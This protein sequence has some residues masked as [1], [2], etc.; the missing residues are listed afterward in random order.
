MKFC[1]NSNHPIK[2]VHR[3]T[4]EEFER[5][6]GRFGKLLT[7]LLDKMEAFLRVLTNKAICFQHSYIIGS[8]GL[9]RR[10]NTAAQCSRA[11]ACPGIQQKQASLWYLSEWVRITYSNHLINITLV[12]VSLA[13]IKHCH[14]GNVGQKRFVFFIHLHHSPTL[15]EVMA[16][17]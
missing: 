16:R 13:V 10:S 17:T 12:S 15:K 2:K 3:G 8:A 9:Y 7:M 14:H 11:C 6:G 1:Q 4:N 5:T